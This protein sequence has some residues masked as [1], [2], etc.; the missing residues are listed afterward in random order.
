ML[1]AT[2]T[3][4][5]CRAANQVSSLDDAPSARLVTDFPAL[6]VRL[7]DACAVSRPAS[8]SATGTEVASNT[9][10]SLAKRLSAKRA[11]RAVT[12]N[13]SGVTKVAFKPIT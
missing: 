4:S 13:P 3:M 10:S 9:A 8:S 5:P 6:A 2:R 11:D 12:L 7:W 1:V